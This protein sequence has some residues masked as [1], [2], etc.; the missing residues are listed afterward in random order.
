MKEKELMTGYFHVSYRPFLSEP[1]RWARQSTTRSRSSEQNFF[2]FIISA[3]L[4]S[5]GGMRSWWSDHLGQSEK[6]EGTS[7]TD[8][9]GPIQDVL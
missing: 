5:L 7:M 1:S 8:K 6:K 3:C 2:C 9:C 4:Y